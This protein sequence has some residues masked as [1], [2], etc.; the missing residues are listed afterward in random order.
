M[1]DLKFQLER[2]QGVPA[3]SEDI[4]A[5]MRRVAEL[6]GKNVLTW[7]LYSKL[8]KYAA[9]TVSLRFGG[10]NKA[11]FAAGL[12]IANEFNYSDEQLYE[13]IMGLWEHYGRQP[14]R[15]ELARLPSF[16]SE[17]PYYRRFRS[18][19]NALSQFVTYANAQDARPPNPIEAASGHKMSRD[20]SLRL[21]FRVMKRDNFSCR[22]CGASPALKP[23][24]TLHID[25]IKPWS[26]G[27]ET[28]EENLQTLCEACNL[29]KSNVL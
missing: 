17:G 15:A 2:V 23:G 25:H 6:G 1:S 19:T 21:R 28:A 11:L 3:S 20:P 22:A 7:R 9:S 12:E 27:G 14:R 29:G 26:H 16:I 8:G 24:L 4:L 10:W 18:W 13:N 5:D